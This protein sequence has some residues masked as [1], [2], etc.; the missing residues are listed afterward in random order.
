[1]VRIGYGRIS[2]A[3][4]RRKIRAFAEL[5][6]AAPKVEVFG[7]GIETRDGD[8]CWGAVEVV[9][10]GSRWLTVRSGS[11]EFELDGNSRYVGGYTLEEKR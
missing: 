6:G 9:K 1:M 8:D 4:L 2:V 5:Y 11:D 3:V 10:I 7:N